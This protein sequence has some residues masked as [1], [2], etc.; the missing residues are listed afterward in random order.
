MRVQTSDVSGHYFP[1]LQLAPRLGRLILPEDDQKGAARA[2]AV[3]SHAL[4]QRQF[5]GERGVI[6]QT[7]LIEK[8]PFE[9]I[10]VAPEGLAG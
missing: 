2:V 1:V 6:G 4:W 7:V 8:T 3:I 5:A 10:G 9:I